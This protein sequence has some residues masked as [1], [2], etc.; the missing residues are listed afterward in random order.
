MP[1]SSSELRRVTDSCGCSW[2]SMKDNPGLW[3]DRHCP[4]HDMCEVEGG[5][6]ESHAWVWMMEHG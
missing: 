2:V 4:E 3:K 1:N 6:K 5:C